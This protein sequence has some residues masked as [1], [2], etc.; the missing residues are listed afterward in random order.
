MKNIFDRNEV[1]SQAEAAA[2]LKMSERT[3]QRLRREGNAPPSVK[4]LRRVYFHKDA[5]ENW[6]RARLM[7]EEQISRELTRIQLEEETK[8][9]KAESFRRELLGNMRR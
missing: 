4:Y 5:L 9:R 7:P 6:A 2:F 3:L 8:R 1:V